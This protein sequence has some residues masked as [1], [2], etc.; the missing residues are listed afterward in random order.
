MK[1][2]RLPN[3]GS[4]SSQNT[5]YHYVIFLFAPSPSS[6][7]FFLEGLADVYQTTHL[8]TSYQLS[9]LRSIIAPFRALGRLQ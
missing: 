1:I 9:M 3:F 6:Q 7:S 4:F 5:E 8:S 2:V